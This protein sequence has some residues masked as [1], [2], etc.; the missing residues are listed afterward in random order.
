MTSK[1]EKIAEVFRDNLRLTPDAPVEGLEYNVS[2]GWDSLTHL[3]I[4][5]G[6]EE[7]FEIMM[8]T[9]DV[10]DMSSFQKAVEIL[11]KYETA[12]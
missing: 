6:L 5:A 8:D 11:E 10:L 2:L 4:I 12:V 9:D 3:N 7:K 1:N